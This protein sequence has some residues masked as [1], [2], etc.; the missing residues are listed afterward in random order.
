MRKL[1][2]MLCILLW[3]NLAIAGFDEAFAA[4]NKDDY[5][6]AAKEFQKLASQGH[7]KAQYVL[8]MMYRQG[9]GVPQDYIQAH[10]WLSLAAASGEKD[11]NKFR[12]LLAAKMSARQIEEA[13]RLAR[14]WPAQYPPKKS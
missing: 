3:S 2:F 6:T 10:L 7:G 14:S 11:A 8:G 1:V 13:Q 12:E 4:Y 5:K 9:Q